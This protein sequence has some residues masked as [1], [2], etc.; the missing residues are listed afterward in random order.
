MT[1]TPHT[2]IRIRPVQAAD[3]AAMRQF[4]RGLSVQSRRMRF[5]VAL[6]DCPA[7]MAAH[8]AGADGVHHQAWV[9]CQATADGERIVGEAR[10]YLRADGS[11]SAELAIAVADEFHGQ[12]VAGALMRTLTQAADRA[13]VKRLFGE[14]L[15][16]NG[17]MLAFMERQGFEAEPDAAEGLMRVV[18]SP[19][20]AHAA[21]AWWQ[22]LRAVWAGWVP[23]A[24]GVVI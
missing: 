5:H 18:R 1:T 24:A 12:G 11:Q 16:D 13:G 2:D 23:V 9:A 17:R 21:Q 19:Q 3:A 10:I 7:A 15:P 8:L 22:A 20:K 6:G 4:V 14:V